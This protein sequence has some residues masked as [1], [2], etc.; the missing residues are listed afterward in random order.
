MKRASDWT[1]RTGLLIVVSAIVFVV[2]AWA[3]PEDEFC[4]PGES[5]LD[6]ALCEA[7]AALDSA[8]RRS[9]LSPEA[10]A[11][12][13]D[14]ANR[15]I[16]ETVLLYVQIGFQHILPMGLDHILF[17]L[18]LVL[19]TPRIN[20]LALQ[21]SAF[22]V[23]HT[24]TLGL[25]ATGVITPSS[26]LVEPLI[27]AS[28]AF[29]AV[30]AIVL[31]DPPPWR[32]ALVFGFG[33]IH[34]LGFAGAFGELGLPDTQFWP[35]LLGFNVGVEIGQVTVAA[36]ALCALTLAARILRSSDRDYPIWLIGPAALAIAATGLFWTFER[37][38]S[39]LSLT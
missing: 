11:L 37:I 33:L 20:Q 16:G 18:G 19:S 36:T 10:A 27:A 5:G 8:D 39:T 4:I 7:L 3:H 35:G 25:A 15:S 13:T 31:R 34:G 32:L 17:V 23:A 9:P 28:I 38:W 14:L 21:I 26:D 2:A 1:M 12:V 22:T 29:V 6:P 24:A 30:E